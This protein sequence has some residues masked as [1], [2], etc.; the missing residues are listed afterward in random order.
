MATRK[1][2]PEAPPPPA[3]L[4]LPTIMRKSPAEE[5][6]ARIHKDANAVLVDEARVLAV[7]AHPPL[8]AVDV[9]GAVAVFRAAAGH[10]EARAFV[11]WIP[12][13]A[14]SAFGN[15]DTGTGD[16]PDEALTEL[17]AALK[18]RRRP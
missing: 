18:S 11:Q 13:G 10:C 2:K 7:R 8:G 5:S 16:S 6:V 3:A 14:R 15:G 17:I 12:R 4:V 1:K 9:K